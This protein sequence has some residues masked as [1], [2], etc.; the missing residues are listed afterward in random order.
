MSRNRSKD[1]E[2][3]KNAAFDEE[4]RY[5][6]SLINRK[7]EVAKVISTGS[8]L[9]DLEISGRRWRGGGIPGGIIV[10]ISGRPGTGKT[11]L[12][13]EICA[14]AQNKGGE[15][16]FEDPEARLDQEYTQTYGVCLAE[17]FEYNRPDTVVEMFT[18]LWEWKPKNLELINVFAGDS[19]AALSTEMEMEEEDKRGQK[20]AKDFSQELRKSARLIAHNNLL[21]VFT[22]QVRQGD[23]GDVTPGGMALPFYASLR[24][25]TALAKTTPY[26]LREKS[27]GSK[28]VT[29]TYGIRTVVKI[30]KS[31]VDVPFGE[32]PV[33]II[34]GYGID[35]IRDE[36]QFYKDITGDSQYNCF[37]KNFS[38][39]EGAIHY[40]EENGYE[41]QLKERTIDLWE[42]VQEKFAVS[43][44]GKMRI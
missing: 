33:S 16:R 44:K 4:K 1:V 43:R 20:R 5:D 25:R 3:I 42:S 22:N 2:A 34:F 21:V 36:L 7:V 31:S 27:I 11:A 39:M 15:A 38:L 6:L 30:I 23:M 32:A 41:M 10:E 28:K 18:H 9:L 13:A 40:I 14:S 19:V 24:L 35:T 8:T 37:T 29:K 26:F 17:N 12:A